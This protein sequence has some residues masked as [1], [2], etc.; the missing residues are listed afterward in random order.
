MVAPPTPP[1]ATALN[2]AVRRIAVPQIL[3][4]LGGGLLAAIMTLF[5]VAHARARNGAN[6]SPEVLFALL[7]LALCTCAAAGGFGLLA[8]R[9]WA[10]SAVTIAAAFEMLLF[11]I[12]TA[13]G[14]RAL[15]LLYGKGVATAVRPERPWGYGGS[16]GQGLGA[17]AQRGP[18]VGPLVAMA[19]FAATIVIG[20]HTGFAL[21]G[22]TLPRELEGTLAPAVIVLVAALAFGLHALLRVLRRRR[23]RAAA[24]ATPALAR[25]ELLPGPGL[26]TCE[27][28]GILERALR[29]AGVRLHA[30]ADRTLEA[31][32]ELS[33]DL[34]R[35][36]GPLAESVVAETIPA[37]E[38][39][40]LD[41]AVTRVAC[42]ECGS[43]ITGVAGVRD[44]FP[45]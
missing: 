45:L 11:P 28:L 21:E 34:L 41:P 8:R 24:S 38:R 13:L 5:A 6:D 25:R 36:H 14:G 23:L 12:G 40:M 7:G 33:K 31:T 44:A 32:C 30:R 22:R 16:V 35:A 26:A 9:P 27:H 1:D 29:D 3:F 20:L 15:W 17:T 42:R 10:L 18:V 19:A 43:S 2:V 39:S 4:G 37:F